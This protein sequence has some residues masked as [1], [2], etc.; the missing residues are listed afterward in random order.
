MTTD[1]L[2]VP[3]TTEHYRNFENA[4]KEWELR[5]VNQ[6]FNPETV[7]E[8]RRVELRRGYSTGDSLWGAVGQVE[9]FDWLENVPSRID[10]RKILP[11]ASE[12][13]FLR[14]A[15]ELVGDY[16]RWISFEVVLD[17]Q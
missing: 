7:Y 5:G 13:E 2:F 8:G 1:R 14:S 10:H 9:Q 16:E 15:K 12:W 4:G 11:G 6:V 3:L 17:G